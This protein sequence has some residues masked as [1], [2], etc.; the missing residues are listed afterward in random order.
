MFVGYSDESKA[1]RIF[2]PGERKTILFRNVIFDESG[3]KMT[4]NTLGEKV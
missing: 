4:Y 3:F 2:F 1:F